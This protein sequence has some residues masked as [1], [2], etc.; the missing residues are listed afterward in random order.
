MLEPTPRKT[1]EIIKMAAS[2]MATNLTQKLNLS[3]FII[4]ARYPPGYSG[5]ETIVY[6]VAPDDRGRDGPTRGGLQNVPP[7]P[8]LLRPGLHPLGN[9]PHSRVFASPLPPQAQ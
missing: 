7:P 8:P 3:R 5:T 4:M 9:R 6:H 2:R 1:N